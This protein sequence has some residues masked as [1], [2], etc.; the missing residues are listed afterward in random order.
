MSSIR[1]TRKLTTRQLSIEL[2]ESFDAQEVEV[3]IRPVR[4]K[5][6]PLKNTLSDFLLS[7]PCITKEE[8]DDLR[9]ARKWLGGWKV[10]HFS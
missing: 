2:P 1:I 3:V 9:N 5:K 4:A 10:R 8:A 6:A 7:G